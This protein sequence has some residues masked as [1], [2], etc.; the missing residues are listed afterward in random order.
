ML[1]RRHL[2]VCVFTYLVAE[3][4]SG[5]I[6][7]AGSDSYANLHDRL[8]S[9]EECWPLAPEFCAQAGIP[10]EAAALTR[11]YRDELATVAAAA[12]DA[13][14]PGNTDLLLEGSRPMLRRCKGAERRPSA[15]EQE[16]AIHDRLPQRALLDILTHGVPRARPRDPHHHPAALPVRVRAARADHRRRQRPGRRGSPRRHA[17]HLIGNGQGIWLPDGVRADSVD[18]ISQA[19]VKRL[20]PVVVAGMPVRGQRRIRLTLR[21]EDRVGGVA[22]GRLVPAV[23]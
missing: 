4:G 16:A 11:H 23:P 15:L 18:Q 19:A 20:V 12:V 1:V 8:M 21:R 17:A 22:D 13:G 5:D 3:L 6:A 10:A 9:W 2:E 7:V 14:Y